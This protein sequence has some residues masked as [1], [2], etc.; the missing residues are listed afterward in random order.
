M[1]AL[2]PAVGVGRPGVRVAVLGATL[3]AAVVAAY[4]GTFSVPFLFDD[5]AAILGNPTIRHLSTSLWP[6]ADST[7]GARPVLNVSLA[8]NF[9]VSGTRVWSY[10]AF[11]LLIHAM[12]A[13][14]LFGVTRRTLAARG[15][16]SADRLGFLVALLWGVHPLLTESVTY[17]VQRAESL[18]GLLYLLTLYAFIR[19]SAAG[20]G[21]RRTWYALSV[22]A[23]LLGMGTKEVMVSAPLVLLL[24]DRTFIAGS[25]RGA[26][27]E[28]RTFYG[29][30][31]GTWVP[32]LFLV[33]G[34]HG[35]AGTAGFGSG[36]SARDYAVMQ[37][38]A[39]VH[40]LR[41]ALWPHPL[42][43]DYGISTAPSPAQA[44]L[45][46]IVIAVL[47]GATLWA[48]VKAP[49][50]GFLGVCF[51]AVLAPTSSFVPIATETMAEHR[52]YLALAPFVALLVLGADR[53]LG[54]ATVP[55]GVAL[56]AA[57]LCATWARNEDY[58]SAEAIWTDTLRKLPGNDRAHS[59]LGDLLDAQGRTGEALAQRADALRLK[60]DS[61]IAHNNM[62]MTLAHIPGRLNDAVAE[63]EEAIRLRPQYAEALNNL[64][65]A[66]E[67]QGRAADAVAR[68][69]E[70][71]RLNPNLAAGHDNLGSALSRIP[72]RMEEA[73]AQYREALRISPDLASAHNNLGNALARSPGRMDEA[74]AQYVEALRL[75]PNYLAAHVNLGNALA[76]IAGRVPEAIAQYEAAIRLNPDIAELHVNLAVMLLDA[77]G[78]R[79][80]ALA[81]LNAALR[82]Q[83]NNSKARELIGRIQAGPE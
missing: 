62:G 15:V 81:H 9:L 13:L 56:A 54:R 65:N 18:M 49:Q 23:C 70:A 76:R 32:L 12:A 30:L 68:F 46:A 6:R 77:P 51:F 5:D 74:I 35:R 41:L 61:A 29:T 17:T 50:A 37:M 8:L 79:G 4:S 73:I 38:P 16:R 82:L 78:R 72:G 3:C 33:I 44:V 58:R 2:A 71:L 10:H 36:I 66:L 20:G 47:M 60:P 48:V 19:G 52:M 25:F 14:A 27:R 26:W 53:F 31:A 21:R 43:F 40:Y 22:F 34:S 63:F 24:Y 69:E 83:P 80:D 45:S 39:V 57:L 75:D 64:G 1:S 11:N 42:I 28:R 59:N 55:I 67:A 7:V